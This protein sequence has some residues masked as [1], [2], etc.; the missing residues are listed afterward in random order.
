MGETVAC[1]A[2][3]NSCMKSG[4]GRSIELLNVCRTQPPSTTAP[5]NRGPGRVLGPHQSRTAPRA[6]RLG[7][8]Q[9]AHRCL[10]SSTGR[11]EHGPKAPSFCNDPH[12]PRPLSEGGLQKWGE[13]PPT[14]NP[15]T[16]KIPG[17]PVRSPGASGR[18]PGA[19]G[20][21]PVLEEGGAPPPPPLPR[22]AGS[23]RS[24][25]R[26]SRT[27]LQ[28]LWDRPLASS[29]HDS[30]PR[31]P[32]RLRPRVDCLFLNRWP[33]AG[34]GG[35][36]GAGHNRGRAGRSGKGGPVAEGMCSLGK[37]ASFRTGGGLKLGRKAAAGQSVGAKA[38]MGSQGAF[39]PLP[40]GEWGG[41]GLVATWRDVLGLP[42]Q[43]RRPLRMPP[44]PQT[45]PPG[46]GI[47]RRRSSAP[48]PPSWAFPTHTHTHTHTLTAWLA[49]VG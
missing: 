37:A 24:R 4:L 16:P 39:G 42:C 10:V 11:Q 13:P 32:P 29:R 20:R 25:F 1:G 5:H 17:G 49:V 21:G 31:L 47:R 30:P 40:L 9:A 23:F 48:Q 22:S 44:G 7:P 45:V 14:T 8:P 6:R 3:V 38:F 28:R 26:L 41:G 18:S 36:V 46:R 27:A 34:G 2:H 43:T 33:E 35:G 19:T 15:T 12:H